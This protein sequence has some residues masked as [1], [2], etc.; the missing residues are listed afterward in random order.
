MGTRLTGGRDFNSTDRADS[1]PVAIVN[2][3]FARQFG[4]DKDA[5]GRRFIKEGGSRKVQTIEIVGIVADAKWI[6]LREESPAMY[7]IPYMQNAGTPVVRF[8]IRAGGDP[9]AV[10][11]SLLQA[12]RDI[13]PRMSV[14]NIV[15]FSEIVNRSLMIERLLAQV[16]TAFAL[17]ALLIA[18]TGTYGI[19]AYD[20]ARR[21][22]EI[23]LRIAVGARPRAIEWMILRESLLLLA[24]GF[25]VGIPAAAFVSRF[26]SVML[27]GLSPQDPAT[28]V[29]TVIGLTSAT[30]AAAYLPA[31]RAAA[32]DP[33]VT[34]RDN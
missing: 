20:V 28:I 31:R 14:G 33:A 19:L 15:P 5:I 2:E 7:Y 29:A 9:N 13:D 23:G 32:L 18:A 34:L 27:F 4:L 3:A 22:K 11:A 1:T 21:R 6:N 8:V 24:V 30:V 17:L 25:A 10:A 12:A 16:S 26:V